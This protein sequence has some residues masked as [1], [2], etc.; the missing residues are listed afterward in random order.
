MQKAATLGL[1]LLLFHSI[2]AGQ[3]V[4]YGQNAGNDR[5]NNTANVGVLR[6][7]VNRIADENRKR[8]NENNG[9]EPNTHNAGNGVKE[10]L[11]RNKELDVL[12]HDHDLRTEENEEHLPQNGGNGAFA[13]FCVVVAVC[14]NTGCNIVD[15]PEG[16]EAE[17]FNEMLCIKR[18]YGGKAP[19]TVVGKEEIIRKEYQ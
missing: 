9:E 15:Q 8:K 14:R 7:L 16:Q 13:H 2:L 17:N 1:P 6:S 5:H 12:C 10:H 3:G 11:A 18:S 4:R 19:Q